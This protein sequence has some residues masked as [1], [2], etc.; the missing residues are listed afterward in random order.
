MNDARSTA[1]KFN[2][3]IGITI[4]ETMIRCE[5][6]VRDMGYIVS[7]AIEAGIPAE[8]GTLFRVFEVATAAM[9]FETDQLKDVTQ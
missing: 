2:P 5:E 6:L 4:G 9:R 7:T 3:F 1:S 8:H